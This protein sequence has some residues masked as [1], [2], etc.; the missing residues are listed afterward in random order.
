MKVQ[1]ANEFIQNMV[2]GDPTTCVYQF[3]F[4]ETYSKDTKIYNILLCMDWNY[5]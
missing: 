2:L 1:Y 4:Y 5:A 3:I